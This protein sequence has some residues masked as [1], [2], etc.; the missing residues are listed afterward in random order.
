MLDSKAELLLNDICEVCGSG[1]KIVTIK[2]MLCVF[3]DCY[4]ITQEELSHIIKTLVNGEYIVNKYYDLEQYCL[5]CLPKGKAYLQDKKQKIKTDIILKTQ[6]AK[7]VFFSSLIGAFLGSL[8][9]F[10]LGVII[11]LC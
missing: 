1:Y 8:I 2:Q 10:L 5:Y 9:T 6:V 4:K 11:K 3:P 7:L